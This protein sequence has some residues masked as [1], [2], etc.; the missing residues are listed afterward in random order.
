M[1]RDFSIPYGAIAALARECGIAN[2]TVSKHLKN[3][4]TPDQIRELAR[5]RSI[6][7]PGRPAH[8]MKG[9]LDGSKPPGVRK[10]DTSSAYVPPRRVPGALQG[11]TARVPIAPIV[12]MPV[13]PDDDPA[14]PARE[15]TYEDAQADHEFKENLTNAQ[16]RRVIALADKQELDNM[17]MRGELV[18]VKFMRTWGTR[19]LV[20]AKETFL[21]MPGELQD[22]MAGETN[23]GLCNK[24][25][26]EYV[27]RVLGE[28]VKLEG[29]WTASVAEKDE[30]A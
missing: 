7:N 26:R 27:E 23:P 29:L 9:R 30:V 5:I 11:R 15:Y 21:K 3:G 28:L 1:T 12:S 14:L 19:F 20:Q 22:V 24:I 13:R 6:K 17:K 25:L 4:R 8:Q 2:V 16:L 10:D 18:P